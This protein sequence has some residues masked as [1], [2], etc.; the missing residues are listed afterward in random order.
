MNSLIQFGAWDVLIEDKIGGV[1]SERFWNKRQ[2]DNAVKTAVMWDSLFCVTRLPVNS[3]TLSI[4]RQLEDSALFFRVP[5][6]VF[7]VRRFPEEA[8]KLPVNFLSLFITRELLIFLYS[9]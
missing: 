1:S 2:S 5:L 9:A 6:S 3:R 8:S 4:Q 7:D